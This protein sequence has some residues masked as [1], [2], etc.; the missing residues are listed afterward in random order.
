MSRLAVIIPTFRRPASLERALRSVLAQDARETLIGEIAV[1]DNDPDGSARPVVARLQHEGAK[2]LYVHAREP[3]VSNARNAGLAATSAPLIAFID[4]DEEAPPHWLAALHAAHDSLAVDVAFGPVRGRA[5]GAADWKRAYL[6][7]FFSRV[8]PAETGVI[9]QVFGCGNSMM[10][11]A[12]ALQGP[13][14]FDPAAN[15]TGG[16]DDRLF[17]RLKAENR[18]FGWAAD[19]WLWE[20]APASR[21]TARYA[22]AR[23]FSFGQ[24]PSQISA[25]ARNWPCVARWMAIGAAQAGLFGAAAL[26]LAPFG[27][28]RALPY[29]DRAVRG[30]GKLL[31]F[32]TLYFYGRPGAPAA[33]SLAASSPASTP[34]GSASLNVIAAKITQ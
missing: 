34:S 11:R 30:L 24:S 22:L 23:A 31:W 1:V 4:D 25:R 3:G 17:A 18:R 9:D 10:T 28:P 2:L 15:Q 20:H 6:E 33:S 8:G 5:D 27:L 12:T 14:P 21:Q 7:R 26:A 19:A 16:E 13:T 29:V 32:K